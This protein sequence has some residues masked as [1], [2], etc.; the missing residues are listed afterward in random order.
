MQYKELN[1]WLFEDEGIASQ[2]I[3]RLYE[4]LGPFN[5][6]KDYARLLK[7]LDAAF[8]AGKSNDES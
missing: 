6:I 7:W 2:R 8:N 1:D 5:D 3:D 4:E